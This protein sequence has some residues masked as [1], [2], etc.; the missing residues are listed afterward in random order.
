MNKN[1]N[2]NITKLNN[3][4]YSYYGYIVDRNGTI[5]S[6]RGCKPQQLTGYYFTYPYSHVTL[7]IDGKP[8]KICKARLVY[9]LFSDKKI[10][11]YEVLKFRDGDQSNVAFDNLCVI[12]R[13]EYFKE[14]KGYNKKKFNEKTIKEMKETYN[15]LPTEGQKKVS[16][17]DM[18]QKYE[19]SLTT[20]QKALKS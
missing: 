19:C 6:N 10:D 15:A 11:K 2:K 9:G 7:V 5:T 14:H 8:R 16:L 13:K 12:S 20:V 3:D 1:M 4:Q 18:C 17:R